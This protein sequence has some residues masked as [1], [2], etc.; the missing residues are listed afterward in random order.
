MKQEE[1]LRD[2]E[3]DRQ[4]VAHAR[5]AML[6]ERELDRQKREINKQ[7]AGEN[8]RLSSEQKSQIDFLDKEVYTNPPTAAY[9][10]QF[11]TSSR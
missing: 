4:R 11:N 10:M 8:K 5:A 9:F 1:K 2:L 3:W 6:M 7:Q